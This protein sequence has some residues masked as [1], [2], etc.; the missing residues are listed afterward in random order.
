MVEQLNGKGR[1]RG[2]VNPL[3]SPE[4]FVHKG[5]PGNKKFKSQKR[6]LNR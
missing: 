3:C 1:L 6:E 2:G 4:D 5:K